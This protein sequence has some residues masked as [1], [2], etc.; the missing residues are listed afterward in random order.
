[1]YGTPPHQEKYALRA[2]FGRCLLTPS[3]RRRRGLVFCETKSGGV[4]EESG[5]DVGVGAAA[6][7]PP[8]KTKGTSIGSVAAL[9]APEAARPNL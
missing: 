4:A 7:A 6:A 8:K 9:L 3:P 5:A 1:M 2:A